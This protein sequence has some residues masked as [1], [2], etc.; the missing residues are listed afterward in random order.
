MDGCRQA[1]GSNFIHIQWALSFQ[2]TKPNQVPI[3][4]TILGICSKKSCHI[5]IKKVRCPNLT[6]PTIPSQNFSRV[7]SFEVIAN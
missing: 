5:Q 1:L 7:W 6:C 4:K 3:F 2:L